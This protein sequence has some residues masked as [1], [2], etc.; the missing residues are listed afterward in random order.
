MAYL[1]LPMIGANHNNPT[2]MK[3]I[4]QLHPPLFRRHTGRAVKTVWHG[5]TGR[6]MAGNHLFKT[7][8]SASIDWIFGVM[9]RDER[10]LLLTLFP[11]YVTI[12]G[13][14]EDNQTWNNYNATLLHPDL[15]ATTRRQRKWLD[16]TYQ[17]IDLVAI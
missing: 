14:D 11:D 12:R 9:S 16:V 2:G 10:Q 13:F 15:G 17:L 7:W 6:A 4:A 3:A 5:Y 8:G 1:S